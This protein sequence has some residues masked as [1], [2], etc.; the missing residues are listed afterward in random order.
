MSNAC[1]KCGRD[2]DK[3]PELHVLLRQCDI[4]GQVEGEG[5]GMPARL[6]GYCVSQMPRRAW[7]LERYAHLAPSVERTTVS[8]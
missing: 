7:M 6:C 5:V 1:E 3:Q 4:K 8:G 2:G